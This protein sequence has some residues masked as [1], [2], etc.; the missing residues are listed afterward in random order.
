MTRFGYLRSRLKDGAKLGCWGA[1]IGPPTRTPARSACIFRCLRRTKS[2]AKQHQQQSYEKLHRPIF[3][4]SFKAVAHLRN[5]LL[6]R[7]SL[8]QLHLFTTQ[9]LLDIDQ[10]QHALTK[11]S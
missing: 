5:R 10:D 9:Q 2:D 11:R 3:I 4:R 7:H 6:R 1:T 8:H